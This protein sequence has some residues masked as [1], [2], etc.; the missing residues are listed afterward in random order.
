MNAQTFISNAM[1]KLFIALLGRL[2]KQEGTT[3]NEDDGLIWYFSYGCNMSIQMLK[4][5]RQ[6]SFTESRKCIVPGYTLSYDYDAFPFSEP[7]FATCVKQDDYIATHIDDPSYPLNGFPARPDIHGIAVLIS[8][9]DFL[10]VLA[11][12]GGNGWNDGSCGGYRIST[13]GAKGYDS[14]SFTAL[15]LTH[16]PEDNRRPGLWMN[17]PSQRYKDLIVN[18]AKDS[19]LDTLYVQWLEKQPSYDPSRNRISKRIVDFFSFPCFWHMF[20]LRRLFL[21]YFK[22]KRY[23]WIS[24]KTFHLYN[25]LLHK[26]LFP[27]LR[28]CCGESGCTNLTLFE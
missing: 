12:E 2:F 1:C 11:T 9:S 8:K 16:L 20:A 10:R 4:G 26:T 17:C 3:E 22:M 6:I 23:P 18:G 14:V 15:T 25:I 7:C 5:K 27:L 13:V 24:A 21:D 19:G 28:F